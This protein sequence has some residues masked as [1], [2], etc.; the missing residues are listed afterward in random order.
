M[1]YGTVIESISSHQYLKIIPFLNLLLDKKKIL[2]EVDVFNIIVVDLVQFVIHF[3][4]NIIAG[5]R[6]VLWCV[7][8]CDVRGVCS[9]GLRVVAVVE[10]V[11]VVVVV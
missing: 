3:D 9:G 6:M 7:G 10:C 2:Q 5:S 1:F 11:V 4:V 8:G